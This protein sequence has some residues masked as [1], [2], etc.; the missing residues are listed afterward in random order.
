MVP[1]RGWTPRGRRLP[2]KVP[3]G[4]WR[5]D[6]L[7]GGPAPS[8]YRCAIVHG[9]ADQR[10]ELSDL[11]REVLVPVQYRRPGQPRQSQEERSSST[12]PFG[13]SQALLPA[14][15]LAR[16][17]PDRTSLPSSSTCSGKLQL[18]S[19]MRSA[20][21]SASRL[22]LHPGVNVPTTSKIQVIE[23]NAITF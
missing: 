10:R 23:P 17:E 3:H 11:Y 20:P 13:Q 15:M 19:S 14:K 18:E 6:E 21:Q 9:G 2:A 5:A 22:S 1:L 8:P 16:H 7:A 4:R 12:Q